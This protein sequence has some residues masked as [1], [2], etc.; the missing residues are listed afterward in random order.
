M[1]YSKACQ[2]INI[3]GFQYIYMIEETTYTVCFSVFMH[4][5]WYLMPQSSQIVYE[6][7]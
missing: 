4:F 1:I 5:R 7:E 2:G 3:L 6:W